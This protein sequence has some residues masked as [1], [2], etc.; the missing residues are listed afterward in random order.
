MGMMTG[1][2]CDGCGYHVARM[3]HGRDCGFQGY[4]QAVLC[5]DCKELGIISVGNGENYFHDD[6]PVFLPSGARCRTCH[7]SNIAAWEL[8]GPCPKCGGTM[9]EVLN[10]MILWD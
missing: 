9:H 7:G 5:H 6:E 3:I 8:P 4:V 10:T 2:H 1:I